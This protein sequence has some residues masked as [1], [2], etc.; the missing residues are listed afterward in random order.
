[1]ATRHIIISRHVIF[2]EF[3]FPFSAAPSA[4]SM[5]SSLDFL[6]QG[7]FRDGTSEHHYTAR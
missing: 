4:A 1:M 3:F 2:Y 5:P 7:L 6:L